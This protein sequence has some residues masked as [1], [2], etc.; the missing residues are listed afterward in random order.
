MERMKRMSSSASSEATGAS[1]GAV[2]R[3]TQS[4]SMA[5][6]FTWLVPPTLWLPP[7][8]TYRRMEAV[9]ACLPHPATTLP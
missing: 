9:G 5:S 6:A 1:G 2:P 4:S 7:A 8:G 3:S